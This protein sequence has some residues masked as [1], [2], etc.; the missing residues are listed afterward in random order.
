MYTIY[1]CI[2]I[3]DICILPVYIC[4]LSLS[5][6]FS[7][8]ELTLKTI[9]KTITIHCKILHF[10][11]REGSWP[12]CHVAMVKAAA[13]KA[14]AR[15]FAEHVL[16]EE[17]EQWLQAASEHLPRVSVRLGRGGFTQE[18]RDWA[19]QH[20][21]SEQWPQLTAEQ[22]K[23]WY[24]EGVAS[25][26]ET[27]GSS[28]EQSCSSSTHIPLD[29]SVRAK[30][31]LQNVSADEAMQ[32]VGETPEE[33]SEPIQKQPRFKPLARVAKKQEARHIERIVDALHGFSTSDD[34]AAMLSAALIRLQSEYSDLLD[35]VIQKS[36]HEPTQRCGRCKELLSGMFASPDFEAAV[37]SEPCRKVR[38]H[39]DCVVRKVFDTPQAA[40]EMGYAC[41][42][43]RWTKASQEEVAPNR[44]GRPSKVDNEELISVVRASLQQHSQDSSKICKDATGEYVVARTLT[45]DK[46][47]VYHEGDDI[48]QVM[49]ESTFRRL[50]KA[51]LREFKQP[52][53]C[54]DM[55]QYCIDYDRQVL[56]MSRK[57]MT[58]QRE[59]LQSMMENYFSAWDGYAE[60]E[61]LAERPALPVE[62]FEHFIARH[63]E[64]E[65][66]PKHRGTLFPCGQYH[67]RKRGSGFPQD[68][69]VDLHSLEAAC[70][71]ELRSLLKL[72]LSYNHHK[73]ANEHQSPI[74]KQLQV[75]P[76]ASCL[77]LISDWKELLT[78]P[79][80]HCASGEQFYAT[81]R[82]EASIWGACLADHR[83][84]QGVEVSYFLVLSDI[85][86][87][88]CLRTNQLIDMILEKRGMQPPV[89]KIALISDP[90]PHYRGY[91]ALYFYFASLVRKWD[92]KVETHFGCEKHSKSICDRL[93]GW[94]MAY[95][96]TAKKNKKDILSLEDLR[97]VLS[98]Q[99][100]AQRKRDPTSPK[101]N[102]LLDC[103]S[104]VPAQSKRFIPADV[105][106][107]RSYCFSACPD[108]RV[109]PC[110]L[111]V[112]IYNHM[113]SSM[114]VS[115]EIADYTIEDCSV[116][117]EWRRGFW[118]SGK[119]NWM[120][121]PQP[122]GRHDH[123]G[124]S[125]RQEYQQANLPEGRS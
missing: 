7:P 83:T 102:V 12:R 24:D 123:T 34:A 72:V 109:K 20:I 67:L 125:R 77:S 52:Q 39:L 31:L 68:R 17:K 91:E 58:E 47:S 62:S 40:G 122:L 16:R 79:I 95:I 92:T 118:G 8:I 94:V 85:L 80:S 23:I 28:Q 59:Q 63:S 108:R 45:R 18:Q 65:P 112:R 3:Y 100:A 43:R 5:L 70:A 27:K 13:E 64:K 38:D 113:F 51:H 71:L 104:K 42:N 22:K 98:Q 37:P 49:S 88:T 115:L 76:P 44:G 9:T 90:G 75:A 101:I 15:R 48:C 99:N 60:S 66:C 29:A 11:A 53:S 110:P 33:A 1:I 119:Q 93:F 81:A 50:L 82:M 121:N 78:L 35:R 41:G 120:T 26:K 97:D 19:R 89:D 74:L 106:I 55:C 46:V 84:G 69:R 73:A 86:D 111:G 25:K 36:K 103:S 107:T 116:P 105:R 21:M 10:C 54:S 57:M 30:R 96:E 124:L 2:S 114:P 117:S 32:S 61:K 87:H 6:S 4:R 56:P 14:A